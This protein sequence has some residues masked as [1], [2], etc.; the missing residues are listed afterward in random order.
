VRRSLNRSEQKLGNSKNKVSKNLM[1]NQG[2]QIEILDVDD[3]Q[4]L[5]KKKFIK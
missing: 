1:K 5:M 4:Q 2:I 3:S